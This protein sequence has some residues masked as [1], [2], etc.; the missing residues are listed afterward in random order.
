[1]PI[2]WQ[3]GGPA[4]ANALDRTARTLS[5]GRA[6][7]IMVLDPRGTEMVAPDTGPCA[8]AH[9]PRTGGLRL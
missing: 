5:I 2:G 1:M 4:V 7:R 8:V 6:P 3:A 9:G